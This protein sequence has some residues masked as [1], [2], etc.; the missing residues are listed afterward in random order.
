MELESAA[1]GLSLSL[2]AFFENYKLDMYR[3]T[4]VR[5]STAFG[6]GGPFRNWR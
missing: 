3:N 6:S 4:L 2:I 1:T 5:G